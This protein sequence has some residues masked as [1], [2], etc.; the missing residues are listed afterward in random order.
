M[1]HSTSD[2][3][4]IRSRLS[5]AT[6]AGTVLG[7]RVV[8]AGLS[9]V[10]QV[11]FARWAGPEHY[12]AYSYAM[13][14]TA[15]LST[16]GG[17]G[18]QQAVLRFLP[19]YEQAGKWGLFRGVVRRGQHVVSA[20][21]GLLGAGGIAA[22][23]VLKD[24]SP[25]TVPLALGFAFLLPRA[26]LAL[27]TQMCVA[28]RQTRVAYVLPRLLRPLS[29]MGGAALLVLGIGASLSAAAAVLL[30][31]LPVL[32][33]WLV[34]RWAFRR[35]L[36]AAATDA[37]PTYASATWL[38]AALP[39]LLVTGF[40][41]VLGQTDLLMLGLFVDPGQVGV[42]RV[43]SKTASVVLFPLFAVNA[44]MAPRFAEAY[45]AEDPDR[46][47]R[48]ASTAV[49]WTVG[50]SVLAA[51]GLLATSSFVLGLFGPSFLRAFPMM[52]I[53]IGG[54]LANAAAGAVGPLL[55][56]TDHQDESAV[57]YGGC[58]A[59]NV[60]LNAVGI[61][62]FGPVGAAIATAGSTVLWNV[63]LFR[64]VTRKLNIRPSIFGLTW[65][66]NSRH[67]SDRG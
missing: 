8:G 25:Y 50:G 26:L 61:A 59:L 30:A 31:S 24:G 6:E 19:A 66:F 18:F 29:M 54:H 11:L 46:L 33:I 28:R 15:L 21:G 13:A 63:G 7:A 5:L 34:Q 52:A 41:V 9:Y 47:Q 51:L 58:A 1:S 27:Q 3:Q 16:F 56:M 55:T 20:A 14:W 49:R 57:V 22:A 67:T 38:R 43:A 37:S 32:P 12:G 60:G 42:Y 65:P 35:A 36:P 4:S 2:S 45:A 64:V 40:S 53:L 39:M 48:L 17:L 10:V 62:L 23:C 44:V